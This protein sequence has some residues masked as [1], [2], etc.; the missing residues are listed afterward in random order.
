MIENYTSK[1]NINQWSLVDGQPRCIADAIPA[2]DPSAATALHRNGVVRSLYDEANT[3]A[4]A[5]SVR[6]PTNGEPETIIVDGD[7]TPQ[8]NPA[9]ALAPREIDGEPNP[10]WTPWDEAQ[11]TV[12][13]ATDTAQAVLRARA[14]E[15]AEGDAELI[16]GALIVVSSDLLDKMKAAKKAAVIQLAANAFA[17]GYT[18]DGT[19]MGGQVLQVRD[20]EDR[21][22][23]LTSQA[24]YSAAVA[25]GNGASLG[26]AFRTI[27]NETFNLSFA[28]G[29]QV[30][31]GMAAW[32]AAIMA[33][34]WVL[35]DQIAAAQSVDALDAID[36]TAG[37][38]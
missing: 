14:G 28:E 13:A 37:W 12:S 5:I 11:A 27:G 33:R 24:A 38:P 30:L 9:F 7:D 34:S 3:L 16:A 22:N 32:G 29:L 20:N 26:A 15:P 21:T 31:L 8:P 23:W 36:V 10:A 35:K 6:E 17:A 4:R 19:D 18:V 2:T 1:D 25:S